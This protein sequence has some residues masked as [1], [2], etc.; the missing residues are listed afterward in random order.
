MRS[1]IRVKVSNLILIPSI[2]ASLFIT[3][4]NNQH[5][6][7]NNLWFMKSIY[8]SAASRLCL[9]WSIASAL[10]EDLVTGNMLVKKSRLHLQ[11]L[12]GIWA[13]SGEFK[14]I[15][16]GFPNQASKACSFGYSY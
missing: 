10:Q 4:D 15:V 9:V 16:F 14:Y 13:V 1:H 2:L 6:S 8:I 12:L 11:F 3:D 5:S 7:L